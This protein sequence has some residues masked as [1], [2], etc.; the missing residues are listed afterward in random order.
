MKKANANWGKAILPT[1][2]F[3]AIAVVLVLPLMRSTAANP[4]L[5]NADFETGPFGQVGTVTGWTVVG[6]AADTS[7]GATG[8]THGAALSAG[9]DTPGDT[10]SQSFST[11]SGVM[12][13]VDFDSGIYGRRSGSP[14]QVNVQVIGS[15]A[16]VNTTITP[17]DAGTFTA[18]AVIFQ[19]YT[20][21]FTANSATTTLQ[22]TSVGTGNAAADQIIDSVSVA[23]VATPTPTPTPTATP[24]GDI[25]ICDAVGA[26]ADSCYVLRPP[27]CTSGQAFWFPNA[28]CTIPEGTDCV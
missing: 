26:A 1:I 21:S 19:H 16:L 17:P 10:I 15:G 25:T 20:F 5:T 13:N 6:N 11:T 9:G 14:L 28:D 2:F 3:I 18:S 27:P 23:Q 7:E 24:A 4:T 22:F 12:Y 8:G